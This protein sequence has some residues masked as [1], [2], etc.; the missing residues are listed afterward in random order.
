MHPLAFSYKKNN[1]IVYYLKKIFFYCLPVYCCDAIEVPQDYKASTGSGI[2]RKCPRVLRASCL[3]QGLGGS[4]PSCSHACPVLVEP[5]AFRSSSWQ[6][7]QGYLAKA[8]CSC[9]K[10]LKMP[11]LPVVVRAQLLFGLC[12]APCFSSALPRVSPLSGSKQPSE[13]SRKGTVFPI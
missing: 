12:G 2:P 9:Q 1:K 7:T 13:I 3:G 8:P 6:D 5:G 4:T 11:Q 10:A